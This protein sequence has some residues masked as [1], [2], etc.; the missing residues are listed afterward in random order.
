M[1]LCYM[2]MLHYLR[3]LSPKNKKTTNT[4]PNAH[5][6]E[7]P[8][9]MTIT[10]KFMRWVLDLYLSIEYYSSVFFFGKLIRFYG[11]FPWFKIISNL[12]VISFSFPPLFCFYS[13]NFGA[14]LNKELSLRAARFISFFFYAYSAII[15]WVVSFLTGS[16][17]DW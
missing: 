14:Y 4:S 11:M 5:L 2:R 17:P 13:N 15:F 12:W 6:K 1:S 16:E 10:H 9:T 3:D 8:G 7:V